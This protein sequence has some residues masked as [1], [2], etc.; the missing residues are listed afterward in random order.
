MKAFISVDLE[1]MPYVVRP[2]HLSLKGSLYEEARR[3]AT[4]VTRVVAEA[5]RENGF[6]EVLVADS[7]GPMVNLL[8]DEL[9]E[10]VGLIRGYPRPLAMVV[11]VEDCEAALFLGYHAKAG[12]THSTFDHT[13][14]GAC[15]ASL[16]INGVEASEFL[17]NA[18]VAGY[19]DVPVILVAGEARLLEADVAL[20]TPWAERVALKRS[21]SRYASYSPSMSRIEG[22]LREAVGNACRNYRQGLT[23]PL[24]TSEP[25]TIKV[26]FTRSGYADMAEL[27][28]GSSRIDGVTVKYTAKDIIEAYKVFQL[29][30]AASAGIPG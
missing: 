24:K 12:T 29:V 26:R 7:H 25:V 14:S 19:Y 18:Y 28:P 5:L 9:P 23:K 27:L 16:E 3:I 2:E 8:V 13:Y 11:G 17:L 22:M 1:G 30:V 4:R 21:F 20:Y 15:I 10:Y 6:E